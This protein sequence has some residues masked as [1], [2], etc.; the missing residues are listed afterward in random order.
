[1]YRAAWGSGGAGREGGCE[2]FPRCP[3][4]RPFGACSSNLFLFMGRI[5]LDEGYFFNVSFEMP[6]DIPTAQ[7]RGFA[8]ARPV[9]TTWASELEPLRYKHSL[10]CMIRVYEMS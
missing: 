2:T 3:S 4:A 10:T 7:Q 1:M 9:V 6:V 5:P 8:S